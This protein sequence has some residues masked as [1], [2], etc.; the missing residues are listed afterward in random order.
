MSIKGMDII[1]DRAQEKLNEV[2]KEKNLSTR[3]TSILIDL[4]DTHIVE[5]QTLT[6][7]TDFEIVFIKLAYNLNARL[8]ASI[9]TREIEGFEGFSINDI[10]TLTDMKLNPEYFKKELDEIEIRSKIKLSFETILHLCSLCGHD[11]SYY[12][13]IIVGAGDESEATLYI[14]AK[15]GH[16]HRTS[17]K[18]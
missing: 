10:A 17:V 9:I 6:P 1:K 13:I 14:C 8:F 12:S 2:L 5:S 11:R 16:R 4:I 7:I 3:Y 15:C 18:E